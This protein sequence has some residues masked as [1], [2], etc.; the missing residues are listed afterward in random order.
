MVRNRYNYLKH[1]V[2][3]TKGKEGRTKSK[4]TTIKTLQAESQKDSFFPKKLAKRLSKI[5]IT[6][7][8][9]GQ[10]HQNQISSC[11]CLNNIAV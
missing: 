11:P 10:N 5:K 8:K 9:W 3:D 2:Q 4:G 7:I 6:Y 1:S